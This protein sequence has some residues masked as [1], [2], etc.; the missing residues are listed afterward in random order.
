LLAKKVENLYPSKVM[1]ARVT[2]K[3][4]D[5]VAQRLKTLQPLFERNEKLFGVDRFSALNVEDV[6]PEKRD[7]LRKAHARLKGMANTYPGLRIAEILDDPQLSTND[8]KK[9]ITA[10]IGLLTRFH[11]QN[12]DKEFLFLDYAP[13]SADLQ[14]LDFEGFKDDEQRMVLKNVKACQ[15][16]YSV[17]RDAA[18]AKILLEQGHHSPLSIANMSRKQ[19]KESAGFEKPVADY[20][21]GNVCA[22]STKM[23][24]EIFGALDAHNAASKWAATDNTDH[25]SISDYLK[26]ID[27]WEALF[28]NLDYCKCEHCRSIFS[29]AAYFVDLMQ[30]LEKNFSFEESGSSDGMAWASVYRFNT[31]EDHPLHLR[32]RR[33]DLWKLPLTCEN[34]HNLIPYL[35]IIN[36]V[37]ENYIALYRGVDEDDLP[38]PGA[39]DRALVEMEV[40]PALEDSADSFRQPFSL[41]LE[42]LAIYLAHFDLNR[43]DVAKLLE[44]LPD[45]IATA[46]LRLSDREYL[47][48][49]EPNRDILFIRS[50]Y[51][52]DF[53][54]SGDEITFSD[55]DVEGSEN[56]VQLLLEATGL[57]RAE[58]GELI[59]LKFVLASGFN[60]FGEAEVEISSEKRVPEGPETSV[61]N[62]IERIHGLTAAILERM[63]R[64]TRLWRQ[65]PWSIKEL[66]LVLVHLARQ[67]LVDG[68]NKATLRYIADILSIQKRFSVSV[69]ELCAL[70]SDLPE[71][72]VEEGKASLFDRLFN[73]PNFVRIDRDPIESIDDFLHPA[74]RD[75]PPDEVD[76]TLHRLLAGLRME[77]ESLYLLITHLSVPLGLNLDST[78]PKKKTFPLTEENLSLL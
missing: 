68:I 53:D 78:D 67:E 26:K 69:E 34:T 56:D 73:L 40:Y 62:D 3:A 45:D 42:R 16:M 31:R 7:D 65:T 44:L 71:T 4:T 1:L 50:L 41:S 37:L 17:T 75:M 6:D 5:G 15:R 46:A 39:I 30:F 60:V 2:S 33:P 48:I 27:G 64:F 52:I 32:S 43:G 54:D 51:G 58:L 57:T 20:Y 8:K 25:Q 49:T 10:R 35:D 70:W 9:Q 72:S 19:F 14:A 76:Y 47:L 59:T 12:P 21:Y 22:L 11:A 13:E 63:H 18:H 36:E 28:G 29:P 38:E 61:Q 23:G 55:S 24:L 77:D 66:H 74:F